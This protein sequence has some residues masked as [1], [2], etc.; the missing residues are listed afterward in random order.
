MMLSFVLAILVVHLVY[1]VHLVYSIELGGD[2]VSIFDV[3]LPE[4]GKLDFAICA[5]AKDYH[6]D[7]REWLEYHKR[8]GT[9][10]VYLF[11]NNSKK[12]M[13]S[14]ILDYINEDFVTYTPYNLEK[15]GFQSRVYD[16]CLTKYSSKHNFIGFLDVNEFIVVANKTRGIPSVLAEFQ[17]E[18]IGGL[19]LNWKYFGNSART[20]RFSDGVLDNY[21]KCGQDFHVKSI[22]RTSRVSKE[23][24]LYHIHSFKYLPGYFSVDTNYKKSVHNNFN[25]GKGIPPPSTLYEKMYIN[26]YVT[27]ARCHQCDEMCEVLKM[28]KTY[29]N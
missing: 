11:D 17:G 26:R 12:A 18:D 19:T 28:P 20:S 29:I 10:K 4:I 21:L 5:V 7:I 9:S 2:A 15:S 14:T 22:V 25:P 27:K 23:A 6:K 8:M 1:F 16:E 3:V 24:G 13:N